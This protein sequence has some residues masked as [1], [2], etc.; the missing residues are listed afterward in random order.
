H[1]NDFH[2]PRPRAR[3]PARRPHRRDARGPRGRECADA[4][5]DRAAE[6]SLHGGADR[7][8]ARYRREPRRARLDCRIAARPAPRRPA[9]VPLFRTLPAQ[10]RPVRSAAAAPAARQRA[11]RRL[12]EPAVMTALLDVAELSKRFPVA[13]AGGALKN[14]RR[15]FTRTADEQSQVHAVDD[16]SFTIAKGETVGLVGESGCGKSTL[17]RA[18]TRLL[19]PS[20]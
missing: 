2:H 11:L 5:A 18:L 17:V 4:R 19:D 15:R 14:L 8:D 7:R 16:V 1:G 3:R 12:L 10:D 20:A 9:A 6:P 13:A